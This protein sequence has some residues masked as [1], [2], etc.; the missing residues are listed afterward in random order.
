MARRLYGSD[1]DALTPLEAIT[2]GISMPL[3]LIH[4]EADEQVPV[5]HALNLAAASL[6]RA[7]ELWIVP[8]VRHCGAYREEPAAYLQRC[9]AF[10]ERTV[11]ARLLASAG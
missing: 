6:H 9:L 4:G 11:P 8:G 2:A 3:L 10:I 1:V 7:D 5:A